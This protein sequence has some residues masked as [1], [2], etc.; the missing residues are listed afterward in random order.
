LRRIP[1]GTFEFGLALVEYRIVPSTG[2][3]VE[4]RDR[5]L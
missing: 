3:F 2:V 5:A 4:L 1:R